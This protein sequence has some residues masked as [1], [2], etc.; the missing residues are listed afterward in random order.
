MTHAIAS[1]VIVLATSVSLTCYRMCVRAKL[2]PMSGNVCTR[3]ADQQYHES[4]HGD[5]GGVFEQ[6]T[7][8]LQG[9][10]FQHLFLSRE[11][12]N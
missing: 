8:K 12:R 10:E 7:L 4:R 9:E 11:S 5:S 1:L 3:R 2:F 6:L